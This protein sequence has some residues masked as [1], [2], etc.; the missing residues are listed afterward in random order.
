HGAC[1]ESDIEERVGIAALLPAGLKI[2]HERVALLRFRIAA[3]IPGRVEQRMRSA[4]FRPA[5]C[6]KVNQRF[7]AGFSDIGILAQ[8]KADIEQWMRI[9]ALLPALLQI[10]HERVRPGTGNVRILRQ[11]PGAIK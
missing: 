3:E 8:V 1:I 4:P 10:M 9:A 6:E 2:M 11:I 5:Y 7:G